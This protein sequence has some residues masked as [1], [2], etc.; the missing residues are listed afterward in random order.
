MAACAEFRW[1]E[2]DHFTWALDWFD[3]LAA[4]TPDKTALWVVRDSGDDERLS[5]AEMR[6]RSNQFANF[7]REHR[8]RRGD[9]LLLMLPSMVALSESV[10]AAIELGAVIIPASALFTPADLA[11]RSSV[12]TSGTS[13]SPRTTAQSSRRCAA[14]ARASPSVTMWTLERVFG[15]PSPST[16]ASASTMFG[17]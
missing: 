8:V 17:P 11:D 3:P 10:L 14:S 9:H 12:A 6:G 2:L 16:L 1:P 4:A 7:P 15:Q 5:Y 13:S